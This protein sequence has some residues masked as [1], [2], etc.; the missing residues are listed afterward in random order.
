MPQARDS[1]IPPSGPA[2]RLVL[3]GQTE[4]PT[5]QTHPP[6]KPGRHDGG[7]RHRRIALLVGIAILLFASLLIWI[8][9]SSVNA[10]PVAVASFGAASS[11]QDLKL[12]FQLANSKGELVSAA[13]S[14][15]VEIY[16]GMGNMLTRQQLAFARSDFDRASTAY[17]VA[18]PK[19][20]LDL[21]RS[22][23][24]EDGL[25]TAVTG[26]AAALKSGRAVLTI[27]VNKGGKSF[28]AVADHI[29]LYSAEAALGVARTIYFGDEVQ[30]LEAEINRQWPFAVKISDYAMLGYRGWAIV[31]RSGS[32]IIFY[33]YAKIYNWYLLETGDGGQSW[34]ITWRGDTV[35][36]FRVEAINARRLKVTTASGVFDVNVKGE[37]AVAFGDANLEAAVREAT[38]LGQEPIYPSD[39]AGLTSLSAVHKNINSLRGME[40]CRNLESLYLQGNEI[41][42]I[43]PL[44]GLTAL[45]V[46]IVHDNQINDVSAL[47]GLTG[48]TTLQVSANRVVDIRPLTTLTNLEYLYL[49]ANDISDIAP[50][51]GLTG[52][53]IVMLTDNRVSDISPLVNNP[54]LGEGDSVG[55]M[56]NPLS[57]TSRTRHLSDLRERG[58]SVVWA[59]AP[60][61]VT[62]PG[63]NPDPDPD[64]GQDRESDLAQGPG[65]DPPPRSRGSATGPGPRP[66]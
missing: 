30:A 13:G 45:T 18:I 38:G 43:S 41:R 57:E 61:V 16:D 47:A 11:S 17:S 36:V 52:L 27:N 42:D 62:N 49:A 63:L 2:S 34:D 4:R 7:R 5:L 10:E 6:T 48:L 33:P 40:H 56:G 53:S 22:V 44:A 32:E 58:V 8:G 28:A 9:V 51:L 31:G 65:P 14:G 23:D 54:G 3:D 66:P 20:R 39:L 19:T 35:P 64:L 25:A 12:T 59:V 55:L 46:L 26:T 37:A 15:T 24:R 50:L 1:R 60:S 29:Q 21:S